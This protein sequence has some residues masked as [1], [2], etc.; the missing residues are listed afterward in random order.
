MKA[1][2]SV[3]KSQSFLYYHGSFDVLLIGE[4]GKGTFVL[5]SDKF[6]FMLLLCLV[7]NLK[8]VIKFEPTKSHT[9]HPNIMH[10]FWQGIAQ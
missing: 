9:I 3:R 7:I 6:G 8:S 2:S 10:H 1:N 4:S 5:Y